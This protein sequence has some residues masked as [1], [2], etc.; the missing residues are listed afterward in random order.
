M[1]L[2]WTTTF[3]VRPQTWCAWTGWKSVDCSGFGVV[4]GIERFPSLNIQR[5]AKAVPIRWIALN[6]PAGRAQVPLSSTRPVDEVG[7]H[8][9]R[10]ARLC[11]AAGEQH[12]FCAEPQGGRHVIAV[13]YASTAEHHDVLID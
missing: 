11:H 3:A 6:W 8:L 4:E 10:A 2:S 12:A 13:L 7:Q 5:H 1:L 9:S